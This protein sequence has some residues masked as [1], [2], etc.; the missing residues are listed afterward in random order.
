MAPSEQLDLI[1]ALAEATSS[2][3]R[4]A[5]PM[6]TLPADAFDR[7][8]QDPELR[9]VTES[10]FRSEH[11]ADAVENGVKLLINV[12]AERSGRS[13][14]LDGTGLMTTVFSERSPVLRVNANKTKSDKS[15]QL[16]YMYLFAGMVAAFRNPRAHSADLKDSPE[17]ALMVL[18]LVD[19]LLGV[20]RK[21][22]RTRRRKN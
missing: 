16:G 22:T 11:Y 10:R 8:L 13:F 19:H 1:R 21:A 14:D 17:T 15:E 6:G 18:E 20:V 5:T 3:R 7:R 9:A 4:P 2:L 12:V